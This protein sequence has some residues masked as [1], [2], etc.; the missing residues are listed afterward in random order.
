MVLQLVR[1]TAI[2]VA[3]NTGELLPHLFTLVQCIATSNGYFLLRYYTFT[4]V[5]PLGSTTPCVARTFL[6]PFQDS[7]RTACYLS[8]FILNS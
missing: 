3:K 7:D 5:F 1:R 2:S 6:S 4:D 8:K